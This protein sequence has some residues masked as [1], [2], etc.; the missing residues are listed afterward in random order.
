MI[1]RVYLL[2]RKKFETD[3]DL[4]DALIEDEEIGLILR[5][6]FTNDEAWNAFRQKVQ[7]AQKELLSD[8]SGGDTGASSSGQEASSSNSQAPS[9]L[10]KAD[11]DESSDESFDE[12]PDIV[13]IIDPSDEADRQKLTNISNIAALRLF[14]NVDIRP[15]PPPAAGTK[16]ISPQNP[17]IDQGG[18]QEIYVGKNVW[19]YDSISNKDECAR[20]VSQEGDFYGTATYVFLFCTICSRLSDLKQRR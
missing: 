20:V 18:W 19:I 17:L 1:F 9:E 3:P 11:N 15:A 7:A 14:N 2:V 16:R 4:V 5:T 12:L 10:A 8:L 13:K 6:D